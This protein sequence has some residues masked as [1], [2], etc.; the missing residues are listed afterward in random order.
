MKKLSPFYR[1]DD[2][3]GINN[4]LKEY[5][6][7]HY[8]L[9]LKNI[10]LTNPK[11]LVVFAGGNAVGKTSLAIRI[12]DEL[13]AIVLENDAVKRTILELMPDIERG[14]LNANT[15]KYTMSLYERLPELT[16]NGLIV[17]DGVIQWYFDR[18]LPIF[19]KLGYIL[20]VIYFDVSPKRAADLIKRRGDT[21]TTSADRLVSI[22]PDQNIHLNRF[23][24]LYVPNFVLSEDNLYDHDSVVL[25]LKEF[26]QK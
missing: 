13:H 18:I 20:F 26:I 16:Q 2:L 17:R 5:L 14:D 8:M 11:V 22:I 4:Q 3:I 9:S 24:D 23:L 1:N 12:Q 10:E 15:W 21:P 6:D 7:E 19:E 25:A